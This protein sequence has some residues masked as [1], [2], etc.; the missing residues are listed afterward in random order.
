MDN[1]LQA[2]AIETLRQLTLQIM[3]VSA[4]VFGIVGGFVSASEKTFVHRWSLGVALVLFAISA[5]LGYAL[6]GVLISL[7]SNGTFDAFDSSLVNLGLAQIATFFFGGMVFTFFV[8]R[9]VNK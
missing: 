4:G 6:H 9:N 2:E 1:P 3:L 7:M 8:I 5:L